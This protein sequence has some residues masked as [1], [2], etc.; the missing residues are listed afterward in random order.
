MLMRY[1]GG[2][3]GHTSTSDASRLLGRRTRAYADRF[4]RE[5]EAEISRLRQQRHPLTRRQ[6]PE[7]SG[8][9]H[10]SDDDSEHSSALDDGARELSDD[11]DFI[12]GNHSERGDEDLAYAWNYVEVQGDTVIE[13]AG[14]DEEELRDNEVQAHGYRDD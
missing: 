6:Q 4:A 3:V 14:E 5:R 12:E 8:D 11:S 9:S 1:V 10:E 2:A 13:I 7:A